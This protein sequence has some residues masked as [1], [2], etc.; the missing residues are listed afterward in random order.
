MHK[1][2]EESL[3]FGF[4]TKQVEQGGLK[5]LS[6]LGDRSYFHILKRMIWKLTDVKK[7]Y[8]SLRTVCFSLDFHIT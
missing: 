8:D 5:K 3:D 1:M 6:L 2:L 7:Y 4:L